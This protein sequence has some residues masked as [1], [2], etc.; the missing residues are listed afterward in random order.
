[1]L[2]E[3]CP[4]GTYWT[5]NGTCEFCDF[6]FYQPD[7][8]ATECIPC[9]GDNVTYNTGAASADECAGNMFTCVV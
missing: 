5:T 4:E 3:P 9:D 7:I 6:N 2:A 1:M 8:N